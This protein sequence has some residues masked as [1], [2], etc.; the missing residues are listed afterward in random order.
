MGAPAEGF[1]A[2]FTLVVVSGKGGTGKTCVAASLLCLHPEA[3]G[4]DG[5]VEAPNLCLMLGATYRESDLVRVPRPVVDPDRCDRCGACA[6]AC[7]FGALLCLGTGP[8][9]VLEE[10]CHGC[11]LCARV[12]PRG[13]LTEVPTPVGERRFAEAG[14]ISCLEGRLF[15][16]E[17]N[18]IPVLEATLEAAATFRRPLVVDGPPGNAC[19]LAATLRHGDYAVLVTEPT[20]FGL[21]DLEATLE[22]VQDRGIPGGI[23][24]NRWGLGDQDPA[25]LG[26][27]YGVPVLGH[28][29][30]SDRVARGTARGQIPLDA[31]PRWEPVLHR[32]WQAARGEATR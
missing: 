12:C 29:P 8:V 23:L 14:R 11:G 15:L 1:R 18:P 6:R 30:F 32:V 5:D 22:V 9:R 25:S 24:V 26:E 27:R 10:L 17:P 4:V 13:A 21:A 20:P 2:P 31:D 19:P 16:G 28:L 3:L 7:R